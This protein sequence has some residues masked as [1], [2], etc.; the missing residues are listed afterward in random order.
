MT[1]LVLP[2]D[3]HIRCEVNKMQ[4]YSMRNDYDASKVGMYFIDG[5]LDQGHQ[6]I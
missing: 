4:P 3:L 1:T 6:A 5:A 2:D